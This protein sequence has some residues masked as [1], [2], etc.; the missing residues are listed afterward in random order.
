[1]LSCNAVI[2]GLNYYNIH[3]C[4][5]I[6][7]EDQ[8]KSGAGCRVST[9]GLVLCCIFH[10]LTAADNHLSRAQQPTASR[11]CKHVQGTLW[12]HLLSRA[13][14]EEPGVSTRCPEPAQLRGG[15]FSLLASLPD[16]AACRQ[17]RCWLKCILRTRVS[18][19]SV[20]AQLLGDMALC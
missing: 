4:K 20:E 1:M 2:P 15:G 17:H 11:C 3:A 18:I 19:S 13:V 10:K 7:S 8:G 12:G 6:Y 5:Q 9:S 16:C 14:N